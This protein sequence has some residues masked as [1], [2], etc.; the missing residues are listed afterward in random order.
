MILVAVGGFANEKIHGFHRLRVSQDGAVR[1]SDVAGEAEPDDVAVFFPDCQGYVGT[2]QDVSGVPEFYFNT[3]IHLE[4]A[5][6]A[7]ADEALHGFLHIFFVVQCFPFLMYLPASFFIEIISIPFLDEG[8]V[9][10]HDGA[11]ATGGVSA[12]NRAFETVFYQLGEAPAVVNVGMRQDYA[13]DFFGIEEPLFIKILHFFARTLV[14]AT[15]EQNFKTIV[16]R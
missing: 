13:V 8:T 9:Q 6:V 16:Q 12:E 3:G 2:T 15:I 1:S 10:Q 11:K 7:V 14:E 4:F 5:T